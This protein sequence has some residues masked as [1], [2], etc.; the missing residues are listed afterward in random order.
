MTPNTRTDAV[1]TA[2]LA[3]GPT[4]L[5]ASERRAI[6]DAAEAI[7][8]RRSMIPTFVPAR[9]HLAIAVAIVA[10]AVA[11]TVILAGL[12]G[13]PTPTPTPAWT[14]APTPT[15]DVSAG[16]TVRPTGGPVGCAG[17][18]PSRVVA[19]TGPVRTDLAGM[20][21]CDWGAHADP[22]DAAQVGGDIISATGS[23]NDTWYLQ[24][25]GFP[26]QFRTLDPAEIV[27][28]YGLVFETTGDD[29]ADYVLGI[30]ND[31]PTAGGFRT[32]VTNLATNQT[33]EQVGPPYG[34]PFDFSHPN[35]QEHESRNAVMKFFFLGPTPWPTNP[36]PN[37]PFRPPVARWYAWASVR[38][39]TDVAVWDYAPDYGWLTT[40]PI[41][42]TQPQPSD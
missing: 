2:W 33:Q 19:W 28:E 8:Q 38:N 36:G 25:A 10:L 35:E 17:E 42:L 27:I 13:Q 21:D 1:I 24:F 9:R 22:I 26:P 18:N 32:W 12:I 4:G 40:D 11:S 30:N 39:G 20:P 37:S 5:A 34:R 23:S 15:A 7:A 16:P 3:D 29:I 14:T 31:A 6:A 41:A